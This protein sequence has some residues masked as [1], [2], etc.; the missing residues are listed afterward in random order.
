M[1]S[2]RRTDGPRDGCASQLDQGTPGCDPHDQREGIVP[3]A[4][5]LPVEQFKGSGDTSTAS[6]PQGQPREPFPLFAPVFA[7]TSPSLL[8]RNERAAQRRL[9][10]VAAS[11]DFRSE[12]DPHA[13]DYSLDV[14]HGGPTCRIAIKAVVAEGQVGFHRRCVDV[15]H[16][17]QTPHV[18]LVP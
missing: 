17:T 9:F 15:L 13:A 11:S 4:R 10:P 14:V 7:R 12:G 18:V 3:K 2:Y 6:R 1:A 5:H 16:Y 8:G